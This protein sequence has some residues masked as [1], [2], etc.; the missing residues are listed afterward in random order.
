MINEL[1]CITFATPI[2]NNPCEHDMEYIDSDIINMNYKCLYCGKEEQE[3]RL[4][5]MNC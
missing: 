2:V 4:R 5:M 1:E 3:T